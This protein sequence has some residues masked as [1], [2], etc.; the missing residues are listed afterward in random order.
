MD[1]NT[2]IKLKDVNFY[3]GQS[4]ALTDISMTFRKK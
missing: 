1:S 2:I 4:R 3:Y